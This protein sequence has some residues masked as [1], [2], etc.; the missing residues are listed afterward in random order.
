MTLAS[1]QKGYHN[2]LFTD[3]SL[4]LVIRNAELIDDGEYMCVAEN[5]AGRDSA[6][7]TLD[8]QRIPEIGP[9][10][11]CIPTPENNQCTA[12]PIESGALTLTCNA[13]G[14]PPPTIR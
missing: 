3:G 13:T 5:R 10:T 1:F 9:N 12:T 14:D 8:V 2:K 6:F 7:V 4:D 11:N